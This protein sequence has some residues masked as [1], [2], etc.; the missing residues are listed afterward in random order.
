MCLTPPGRCA[1][2]MMMIKGVCKPNGKVAQVASPGLLRNVQPPDKARR[3]GRLRHFW[4]GASIL[5]LH[6]FGGCSRE[7]GVTAALPP[8]DVGSV[9]QRA[10]KGDVRA[11]IELG[12]LYTQGGPVTNSYAEAAKWFR[13]AADKGDPEGQTRLGELYEAGQGVEKN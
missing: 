11:Q 12:K 13:L 3:R 6:L 2:Q 4:C 7:S 5:A 1:S 9:R 8:V 10:E